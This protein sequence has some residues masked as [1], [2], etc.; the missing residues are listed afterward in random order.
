MIS[1]SQPR[2]VP[3]KVLRIALIAQVFCYVVYYST[4]PYFNVLCGCRLTQDQPIDSV[5]DTLVSQCQAHNFSL[6]GNTDWMGDL[7]LHIPP[8][9]YVGINNGTFNSVEILSCAWLLLHS[10]FSLYNFAW[11][12]Q[13]LLRAGPLYKSLYRLSS[14]YPF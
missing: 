2:I 12:W 9:A 1:T 8:W 5:Y 11:Q 10:S 6:A 7:S 4:P 14:A 13:I 3:G